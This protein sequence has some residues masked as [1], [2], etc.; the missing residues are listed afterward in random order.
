MNL[1]NFTTIRNGVLFMSS[2]WQ[3]ILNEI[4]QER[5]STGIT[6]IRY[7]LSKVENRDD[8]K[9][10]S[11]MLA[12]EFNYNLDAKKMK[13]HNDQYPDEHDL[14]H[15][16]ERHS[17][18][19]HPLMKAHYADLLW[20]FQKEYSSALD[21]IDNYIEAVNSKLY[22][23]ELDAIS[24]LKRALYLSLKVNNDDKIRNVATAMIFLESE[25]A[26]DDS[27]GSWGFSYEQLVENQKVPLED[28]T[29]KTIIQ[30]LEN[31]YERL[32]NW[33]GTNFISL[34]ESVKLLVRY[35]KQQNQMEKIET[36]LHEFEQLIDSYIDKNPEFQFYY[37]EKLI[38][39]YN[40]YQFPEDMKR[41]MKKIQANGHRVLEGFSP[42]STKMEITDKQMEDYIEHFLKLDVHHGI[43]E[44]ARVHITNEDKVKNDLLQTG[45]IV[46]QLFQ[47]EIIDDEGRKLGTIGTL[48]EDLE[49]NVVRRA[50]LYFQVKSNFFLQEL[51]KRFLNYHD[52]N[53]KKL[54]DVLGQGVA[55]TEDQLEVLQKGIAAYM[56]DDHITA[57]HLLIPQIE[58]SIRL[59]IEQSNG[60]VLKRT[61]ESIGGYQ[62]KTFGTLLEDPVALNVFGRDLIY[63]LKLLLTDDRSLNLRNR[64][65]HGLS[66]KSL[67][68]PANS[69][70]IIHALFCLYLV[71][72]TE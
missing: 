33:E 19:N 69:A 7:E 31:R 66:P 14:A 41:I 25:I 21:A 55:F 51:L 28:E 47:K 68:T 39:Y 53:A 8:P 49:G 20:A 4:D 50:T 5:I 64:I 13:H 34:E 67:F 2:N 29:Q 26:E 35:Y 62:L 16:K 36:I 61:N 52:L 18:V 1:R 12:F 15:W 22:E 57:L 65:S 11:E 59:I 38:D 63:H 72:E 42:I 23:F 58:K 46:D 56:D 3:T 37:L 71:E 32:K 30:N 43:K 44:I 54:T 48:D 24:A 40:K 60:S 45:S 9:L 17:A 10:F 27:P 70:L 6:D